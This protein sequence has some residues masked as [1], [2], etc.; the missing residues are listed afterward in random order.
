MDLIS[1]APSSSCGSV[2]VQDGFYLFRISFAPSPSCGSVVG[3]VLHESIQQLEFEDDAESEGISH[4]GESVF[5]LLFLVYF[6]S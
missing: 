1:F 4:F 5:T 6:G 3:M 2:V